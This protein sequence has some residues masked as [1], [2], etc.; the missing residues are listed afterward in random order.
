MSLIYDE[1]INKAPLFKKIKAFIARAYKFMN[2]I[3]LDIMVK[4]AES[5]KEYKNKLL[6]MNQVA[7]V[8]VRIMEI[9][10][11][12]EFISDL[13]VYMARQEDN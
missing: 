12:D 2:V 11:L 13:Y 5:K 10:W 6:E 1:Q 7:P 4:N 9:E 3:T 8:Q